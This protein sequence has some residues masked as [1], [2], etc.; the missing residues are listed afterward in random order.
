MTRTEV[1]QSIITANRFYIVH[2]ALATKIARCGQIDLEGFHIVGRRAVVVWNGCSG[3]FQIFAAQEEQQPVAGETHQI[4]HQH[5]LH[6]SFRFELKPLENASTYEDANARSRN[7]YRPGVD[8]G[9]ALS[10]AE[11]RLEVLWKE[12]DETG[13]N[14]QFHARSQTGNDVHRIGHQTPH[15]QWDIC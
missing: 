10:Q 14:H 11:L 9:L 4:G 1:S 8:T 2:V 6:G 15:R 7:G 5:E 12:N 13:N 3:H